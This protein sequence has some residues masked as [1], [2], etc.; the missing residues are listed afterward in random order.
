M[1]CHQNKSHIHIGEPVFGNYY[2]LEV[3]SQI[4]EGLVYFKILKSQSGRLHTHPLCTCCCFQCSDPLH[5]Q[6]LG[7]TGLSLCLSL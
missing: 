4:K 3:C 7:S 1:K 6:N 2:S 5:N